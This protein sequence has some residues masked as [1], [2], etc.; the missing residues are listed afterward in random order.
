MLTVKN[1]TK[2]YRPKKGLPVT[3][4]DDV[5]LNF[6]DKGMVFLL[7]KSGSGKSTLLNLIGG[8]DDYSSGEIIING[9]SCKNF[10]PSDFDAYRNTY[11]GFI[12]QEFN[13]LE[14]YN[15]GKNIALALE[16]QNKTAS[17]DTVE[18]LMDTVD[19]D[20]SYYE[21]KVTELSGGQKQRVA[22]ARALVKNPDIILADEPTGAL[23]STTGKQVLSALK[24]ISENKLVI[25]VSHDREN[26]ENYGD[27]I[28]ELAD[29]K[30]VSDRTLTSIL[31]KDFSI[32]PVIASLGDNNLDLKKS[33]L[34]I[35]AAIKMGI[36]ALKVKKIRLALTIILSFIAFTAF[37]LSATSSAFDINKSEIE[38]IKMNEENTLIAKS[39]AVGDYSLFGTSLR[40]RGSGFTP[41][42]IAEIE[43]ITGNKTSKVFDEKGFVEQYLY[44]FSSNFVYYPSS[45]YY[46]DHLSGFLEVAEESAANLI[47]AAI[48]SRLPV[49]NNNKEIAISDYVADSF[50]ECGLQHG[51]SQKNITNY[52]DLLGETIA[53]TQSN[54]SLQSPF[55]MTIVGIYKTAINKENYAFYK[56]KTEGS[57]LDQLKLS[58]LDNMIITMGYVT[59]GFALPV[60]VENSTAEMV[61]GWQF[62]GLNG[63]NGNIYYLDK[64]TSLE[65][66]EDVYLGGKTLSSLASNEIVISTY[67]VG[68]SFSMYGNVEAFFDGL[69]EEEKIVTIYNNRIKIGEYKVAGV[70]MGSSSSFIYLPDSLYNNFI[71]YNSL[72]STNI[73]LDYNLFA[74]APKAGGQKY[75][76]YKIWKASAYDLT[77]MNIYWGRDIAP[78]T[79]LSEYEIVLNAR[80]LTENSNLQNWSEIDYKKAFDNMEKNIMFG[81]CIWNYLDN[82]TF[83]QVLNG[84]EVNV[85]G[86]YFDEYFNA[87]LFGDGAFAGAN[88]LIT[89]PLNL[90]IKL[91]DSKSNNT[92]LFNYLNSISNNANGI[93]YKIKIYSSSTSILDQANY[94]TQSLKKAFLYA[95]IGISIFAGLL[96]MN[97]IG[98]SIIN[99]KKEIGVLRAIGASGKDVCKIFLSE[100][101]FIGLINFILSYITLVII[102]IVINNRISISVLLPG[103]VEAAL[104]LA[105]SI[106][107]VILSTIIPIIKIA[108]K[109]P[110]DAINNR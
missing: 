70:Y 31:D 67:L 54:S 56:E 103:V 55:T 4:L 109:K 37:G 39:V 66:L 73:N 65:N 81:R 88:N 84:I 96:L 9:K 101:I 19:L 69:S 35:K 7:G 99:K 3:A 98:V 18:A 57:S 68:N 87:S 27:R 71:D 16:I 106:V 43:R 12:F 85:V 110:I 2:I 40:D 75:N 28:I 89:Y 20:K 46:T 41:E 105:L 24:K 23:D 1:L 48:G 26:A 63:I 104:M 32:A 61:N 29:G 10:K 102:S 77:E 80:S 100:G 52:G 72:N 91:S 38:T 21:R 93:N 92:K 42:Q 79:S 97:F 51:D 13:I 6:P 86:I 90:L 76:T 53:L 83:Y 108:R 107:V 74:A 59:P 11:I 64:L 17:R 30:V 22:I 62:Q 60:D 34:P 82:N 33:R 50:L 58:A 78:K 47:P 94:Y 14:E 25:V 45:I 49:Q 44:S 36:S 5:T 8:L 15:V 95:S